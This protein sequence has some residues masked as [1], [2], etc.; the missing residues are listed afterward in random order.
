MKTDVPLALSLGERRRNVFRIDPHMRASESGIMKD[1][2][3]LR[4]GVAV[5]VATLTGLSAAALSVVAISEHADLAA[6][7]DVALVSAADT[8]HEAFV[9]TQVALDHNQFLNDVALQESGYYWATENP[10][11]G[12][13]GL[14]PGML[15]P[16]DAADPAD[17]IFNGA[18]SRFTESNLV[19]QAIMQAQ[20]DHLLGVNQTLD[21]GGYETLIGQQLYNDLIGTGIAPDSTLGADLTNLIDADTLASASGFHDALVTLQGDLMQ[22]A[23]SDLFGMFSIADVTP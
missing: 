14:T 13:L 4:R 19:G 20:L 10:G 22:T 15:F 16:G 18:F 1:H 2:N 23:W 3:N 12:G 21:V 6:Q 17:S 8:A 7:R 9:D 11:N 5:G